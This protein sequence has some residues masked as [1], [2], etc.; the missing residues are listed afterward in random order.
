MAIQTPCPDVEESPLP[1]D[2]MKLLGIYL[3]DHLAGATGGTHRM[4]RLARAEQESPDGGEL[5]QVAAEI[6]EDQ[7]TLIE[8]M[9]Q[10]GVERQRHKRAAAW[11]AE[12]LGGLKLNGRLLRRSPLTTLVELEMMQM[13]VTG[14]QAL[15]AT[16]LRCEMPGEFDFEALIAR[17]KRQ[18][19][20]LQ[21]V[22]QRRAT[23]SFTQAD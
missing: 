6:E 16:L 12:R 19:K 18:R 10:L 13:A 20:V 11:A 2:C 3:N 14:K 9:R 17:S 1:K 22:H 21:Q 8:V 7:A 4:S 23:N 15:W 5:A